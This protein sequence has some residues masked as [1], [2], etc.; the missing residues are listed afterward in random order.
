MG[1][2]CIQMR[3][4]L[5][6]E[7][8]EDRKNG[9]IEAE[10]TVESAMEGMKGRD[11][12][13]TDTTGEM[14]GVIRVRDL[15]ANA[16]GEM[17]EGHISESDKLRGMNVATLL[18]GTTEN[19]MDDGTGIVTGS[20]NVEVIARHMVLVA[21]DMKR[22]SPLRAMRDDQ[23]DLSVVKTTDMNG[24]HAVKMSGLPGMININEM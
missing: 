1:N 2:G 12:S 13:E 24:F 22:I 16:V 11:F 5:T 3:T 6:G 7:V 9:R 8:G 21:T 23:N 10:N 18:G 4:V 20:K 15:T 14:S 19:V 17:G